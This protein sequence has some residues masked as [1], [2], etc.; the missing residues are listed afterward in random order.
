MG[1]AARRLGVWILAGV[2]APVGAGT[3]AQREVAA[4]LEH[5]QVS[6]QSRGAADTA[7][8]RGALVSLREEDARVRRRFEES[9]RRPLPARASARLASARA[10][11]QEGQG[12]L[13]ELVDRALRAGPGD[14]VSLL[15][16]A[17]EL[18]A[19]IEAA[20]APP[21]V[22]AAPRLRAPRIVA[23][24]LPVGLS[25]PIG[26]S[27][28]VGE[29][30][31]FGLSSPVGEPLAPGA[32]SFDSVPGVLREAAAA[33]PGPIE[34]F[35]W[36]RNEMR[37][38]FYH[39]QMKG[40]VEAYRDRS[41]NDVDTAGVLIGLLRAKGVP[42]RYVRGVVELAPATLSR[43]TGVSDVTR[44]LRVLERAGIPH[45]AIAGPAGPSAVRLERVWVEA[46]VPYANYRG[47]VVDQQGSVWISLDP[48]FK[49]LAA[50]SGLDV[51]A[52][53]GF[54]PRQVLDEYVAVPQVTTPLEFVR[55]RVGALLGAQLPGT[56]Y[57]DALNSRGFEAQRLA[58][59][60]STL[61]YRVIAVGDV[62]YDVEESL[63]HRVRIVGEDTEGVL[64]DVAVDAAD[65]F[66][67]RVTLGYE[68]ST[69][70]DRRIVESHGGLHL[71]PPYLVEVRPVVKVAGM[72]VGGGGRGIGMAVRFDLR[73]EVVAP[74]GVESTVNRVQAGNL[75]AIGLSGRPPAADPAE[76]SRADAILA[77]LA[78]RYFERWNAS[79]EELADLL[80]VVPVRPTLSVCLVSSDV[81][82]DYAGGDPLY[83]LN[84]EWKGILIDADLR[85]SA[86]V[87]LESAEAERRFLL[88]S[89][90]EG[91]V[92]EDRAFVTNLAIEAV[93]TA[94]VLGLASSQGLSLRDVTRDNVDEVLDELPFDAAVEDEIRDAALGGLHVRVP[95]GFVTRQAWRGVGY[96]MLDEETGESAWQLQGGH[97][98]GV[99][100]P[101]VIDIPAEIRDPLIEQGQG[102]EPA[103]AD[104]EVRHIEK[105]VST[106]LQEGTVGFPVARPLRVLVTDE[107][108]RAVEGAHV[109]F[110]SVGGGGR[111]QD[112]ATGG[113]PTEQV[114][115]RS[116]EQGE[117]QV[118]QY[119]GK[120]TDVIPRLLVLPDPGL[121]PI[122]VG[123]NLVTA[124]SGSATLAEPF[125]TIALPDYQPE[126]NGVVRGYFEWMP[127]PALGAWPQLSVA[128]RMGLHVRDQHGNPLS[129][130]PVRFTPRPPPL[131]QPPPPANATLIRPPTTTPGRVLAPADYLSCLSLH[132]QPHYGECPGEAPS[133]LTASTHLG[134]F[135]YAVLGDSSWSEYTYDVATTFDPIGWVTYTTPA[136]M[137]LQPHISQ[138]PGS[139]A[140]SPPLVTTG[141][142]PQRVNRLG[143]V[144][145]AY[146][147]G[148]EGPFGSWADAVSEV[149]RVERV[150]DPEGGVHFMAV[151]T[152]TWR[153]ERLLDSEVRLAPATP[154]TGVFPST[155]VP[156]ADG[157][158]RAAVRIAPTPQ[159]N[160]VDIE[161]SHW[162]LRLAYLE[163][164]W[165]ELNPA[166]VNATTLE[167]E[168]IQLRDLPIP[169]RRRFA[170]WGVS[171]ELTSLA[172]TPVT[173]GPEGTVSQASTVSARI[174][175]EAYRA[176]LAAQDALFELRRD[177]Q[178]ILAANGVSGA[179]DIPVG[180][181]FPDD[182]HEARLSLLG[183]ASTPE[184]YRDV[185]SPPLEV[186]RCGLLE[187]ETPFVSIPM[188]VDAVN[189]V[190]C[191][192]DG[193]LKFT[194]CEASRVTLRVEGQVYEGEVRGLP[195]PHPPPTVRIEDLELPA[196]EYTVVFP[197]T[198]LG[199]NVLAQ[200]P[201]VVGAVSLAD[202]GRRAEAPG[203]VAN[204]A[205]NRAVLPVGRTFVKGIDL[206]D[207]HVVRSHADLQLPGRHLGLT[208]Q[209]TYS[210]AGADRS[211]LLGAGWAFSYESRLLVTD[212]GVIVQT[213]EGGSQLFR[214]TDSGQTF[215]PQKG[216][217]SRLRRNADE[218]FDF[219]DKAENRH[220]FAGPSDEG[221]L[222]LAYIEEPHGDRIELAYDATPRL[223]HVREVHP[224]SPQPVRELDLRY[225][226][227][228]GFDRISS[229]AAVG[230]GIVVQ[231]SYDE[232]GN[233]KE[234]RRDGPP[235]WRERYQYTVVNVR[236][237][238]QLVEVID[239]ND[240]VTR[241]EYY[242]DSDTFPGQPSAPLLVANREY[243]RRVRE[244]PGGGSGV[245]A[246]ELSYDLSD[247]LSLRWR[248]TVRDGRG[249]DTVYVLNANGGDLQR[250][251]AAGTDVE[252]TT[253]SEWAE[254]DIFKTQTTDAL[255]RVTRFGHDANGN[256]TEERIETQDLGVVRRSWTYGPFNRLVSETDAA[257]R[258]TSWEID[259]ANGDV[260]SKTDAAG[261]TTRFEYQTGNHG[262][263]EREI[264]PRGHATSHQDHDTYGNA[265]TLV[266]PLGHVVTRTFDPR[267]RLTLETDSMGRELRQEWD[268]LD[269]L[270]RRQ[271]LAGNE[272]DEDYRWEYDPGGQKRSET[273]PLGARTVLTRDGL[274][275]LVLEEVQLE[276]EVLSVERS[277]DANGNVVSERD[278]RG[279]R[280]AWTYDALNRAT[281]LRIVNGPAPGP[282]GVTAR[283]TYD[284]ADRKLSELDL[285]GLRTDFEY[286]GLYRLKK[287]LLP[288]TCPYGRC[289][290]EYEY[291]LAGNRTLSRDLGGFLER[292]VYDG[293]NRVGSFTDRAGRTW[294]TSYDDPEGSHVNKSSERDPF[295]L[296]TTFAYDA[297]DR[298]TS[299]QAALTG[300][301]SQGE[302]YTTTTEYDDAA[303]AVLVTDPR[304]ARTRRDLDG[305]DRTIR[306]VVDE[307]GLALETR[308][309]W[310]GLSNRVS[311]LD[312]EQHLT[313][314]AYDRAGRLREVEDAL[315]RRTRYDYDGGGLRTSETD[316]RGVRTEMSY[317][318]LGR[319]TRS[320][321]VPSLTSVPWSA[322]TA[323]LDQER[324]QVL[325]DARGKQ[326]IVALDGLGRNVAT[327]HPDGERTRTE[328]LGTYDR[329]EQ[330]KRGHWRELRFDGVGRPLLARDPEP[331]Q[332]QTV[333]TSYDDAGNRSVET[334]RR[335]IA[336]ETQ[337][338]S[339]QRLRSVTR[340]GVVLEEHG[341][342]A[343]GNRILS[344]DGAGRETHALFDAANRLVARTE[345]FGTPDAAVTTFEHDRDGNVTAERDARA[346]ALGEPFSVRRTYDALHRVRTATDGE[347]N[348]TEHAYDEE[349]HRTAVTEPG[350]QVTTF[351]Y[352]EKGELTLVR[353]PAASTHGAPETRVLHD[354]SRNPLQ[355][356]DA[357][358]HRVTMSWDDVGRLDLRTQVAAPEGDLVTDPTY[359]ANG[360]P[361]RWRDPK[362]QEV[363]QT[364]DELD[365]LQVKSWTFA[366]GDPWRPWRHTTSMTYHWDANQN[367]LRVEESVASEMGP[368]LA[369]GLRGTDPAPLQ[370]SVP[371]AWW[372]A[373]PPVD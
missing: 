135:A 290:E 37:P 322:A 272:G 99:T 12:R 27:S 118:I 53:L 249:I 355:Q 184:G 179:Y 371:T 271:R 24:P 228:G 34:V 92:L 282:T 103:P 327:T 364:F 301:G 100:T 43:L 372:A 348:R 317:D 347:G 166:H 198:Y 365:R 122:Q 234:V 243:I 111:L 230:L 126:G 64:F 209:R 41:G 252:R 350:L 328:W 263:L 22:S 341:Y 304:G 225:V 45:E 31:P 105:F 336:R 357:R 250:V 128:A 332:S 153:R 140:P 101:A 369:S 146:A 257:G 4:A 39:G 66:G 134:V 226:K 222:R 201:F 76:D 190:S 285:A 78:A 279:V 288:E 65:L 94:S 96:L 264:G 86:P 219:F 194:L 223:V 320:A 82:V 311:V 51:A 218:S 229:I 211:G 203:T 163:G 60:P 337:K 244:Y 189:G 370:C 30:S 183:V 104:A 150:V 54:D 19:R 193:L 79:D 98:G 325:T 17:R 72:A 52:T 300:G 143:N 239:A 254:T 207:G 119:L 309:G 286:D 44:A 71:T 8:L 321:V 159:R 115:V 246:T 261:N 88:A 55:A 266:G 73:V 202:P 253:V 361:I 349:G 137:C 123:L 344:R 186:P 117:A 262:L 221:E 171:P 157:W 170:L 242:G 214:S 113:E 91:S 139:T 277:Y 275:R 154:G 16:Q 21:P 138:C 3:L 368:A 335:G 333:V 178:T 148:D 367:L 308:F 231:Y 319:L 191:A 63:R 174:E 210:S 318:N 358:G 85:A 180:L 274:D 316:R 216:Y 265:R 165:P 56:T 28:P 342:D 345:G 323:Y 236:D 112:P 158:Y 26:L 192:Q 185:V 251:E 199:P 241:Y 245:V 334:D 108:G 133:V 217:H 145:E 227:K 310:D 48:A 114:T 267:G 107:E 46:H 232:W 268:G 220:H 169:T 338:D 129:N 303:H 69:E 297:L 136:W 130:F 208:A 259:P 61:P 176:L 29:T 224:E 314:N 50:P 270:I 195:V 260:L 110:S 258:T 284:A 20:A 36:V 161:S 299:R 9:A 292:T 366:A 204:S 156:Q 152:N 57:A 315:G 280:R 339:L 147:V 67:H 93:S 360:N 164:R 287:K 70:D 80:R 13:I 97:S 352:G 25:S 5:A 294:T 132:P 106:D 196:G 296:V 256:L 302:V 49:P 276:S 331:F 2:A 307:S 330:D 312:P 181:P 144:I 353:Q 11:Y 40:P 175:P 363:A 295:G 293:L 283:Y 206:F 177:G 15:A 212:C 6:L 84:F 7:A 255:G 215:I 233:L 87:G 168:R 278:R 116:N 305:L 205:R 324:R 38:E 326:T 47:A 213:A 74:G 83:P 281:E 373:T 346:A 247:V 343:N 155:A 142:R 356:T 33:L 120:R 42:A 109:T 151:G 149:E 141:L 35:E 351:E 354:P 172:P 90:L 298:E 359:D 240:H 10:A 187:L 95:S 329:R 1:M 197:P 32:S 160:E 89:G 23:P 237:R 313:R 18:H 173:V 125:S 75:T 248:T 182:L 121:H 235:L 77:L 273:N 124:R 167:V 14:Q 200:K 289:F 238:H 58:L 59:L 362:G 102:I 269:R 81:E 131:V 340:A 127:Q 291:D 68:P 62:S 162:P 188:A 306:E